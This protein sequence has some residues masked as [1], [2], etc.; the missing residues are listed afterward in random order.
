M[1]SELILAGGTLGLIFV[2][3]IE[4]YKSRS[5]LKEKVIVSIAAV[6]SVL[7]ILRHATGG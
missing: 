4:T 6:I 7:L 5:S 3:V 2:T 1:N